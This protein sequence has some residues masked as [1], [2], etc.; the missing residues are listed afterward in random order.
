MDSHVL[1]EKMYLSLRELA[2]DEGILAS[3]KEEIYGCIFGRDTAITVLKLLKAYLRHADPFLLEISKKSLLTLIGL[4]G[5][6]ENIENGEE[7]G[8]FIHEY[9]KDRYEHLQKANPPWFITE[10]GLFNYDSIDATPLALIALWRY[11]KIAKDE[12]FLSSV[13][14][15]IE[16]GLGWILNYAD[17]DHDGILEFMP[18]P[19]RKFGGLSIQSWTDSRESYMTVS[20]GLPSYPLAPGEVQ[21]FGWLAL[22]MWSGFYRARNDVFAL[23]LEKK[24]KQMKKTFQEKFLFQDEGLWYIAQAL[25][26]RKEQIRTITGNPLLCLW[27]AYDEGQKPEIIIDELHI[28]EI[29]LRGFRE[30]LFDPDAG[31]RTMSTQSPTY[32]PNAD[33]YHNGSFWPML[34]GLVYEG[35]LNFGF[36]PEALLLKSASLKPIEYFQSAIELYQKSPDGYVEYCSPSGQKSCRT[37]AWSAASILHMLLED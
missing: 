30:D 10:A 7:P 32:N 21:A 6:K 37:Q 13:L 34:N 8:K 20:G 25:D 18:H 28:K 2:T 29:V 4:Q 16:A 24:A 12:E 11:G 1:K 19:E 33:S 9:R 5:K 14:P 27:A 31:I 23:R 36:Y 26:G 22:K 15:A 17:S 35:L 3:A